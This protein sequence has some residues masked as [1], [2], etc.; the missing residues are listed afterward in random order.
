VLFRSLDVAIRYPNKQHTVDMYRGLK[1]KIVLSHNLIS[2]IDVPFPHILTKDIAP[3]VDQCLFL[4]SDLHMPFTEFYDTC[5]FLNPGP[6]IKSSLSDKAVEAGY[7]KIFFDPSVFVFQFKKVLFPDATITEVERKTT[8]IREF[9]EK[10]VIHQDTFSIDDLVTRVS[11][12]LFH[13][14]VVTQEALRWIHS[15]ESTAFGPKS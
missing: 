2:P 6:L 12:G 7:F 9:T 3:V 4:C 10:I 14:P 5:A 11:D 8:Y 1:N 13:D 15:R